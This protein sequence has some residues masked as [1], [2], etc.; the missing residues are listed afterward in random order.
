MKV[1][2]QQ[3]R[4]PLVAAAVAGTGAPA[5]DLA[6]GLL[7]RTDDGLTPL[8]AVVAS[9]AD[10]TPEALV[11]LGPPEQLPWC[12][13][14]TYLGRSPQAPGLLLPTVKAPT[15]PPGLLVAALQIQRLTALL[16]V[17]ERVLVIAVDQALALDRA[18]LQ[19]FVQEHGG[20]EG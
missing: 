12:D 20:P 13:G 6:T 18:A 15:V 7:R 9:N 1:A 3:R 5:L 17:Q 4:A 14:A 10:G 19:R 8:R 16:P 11:V 2:W